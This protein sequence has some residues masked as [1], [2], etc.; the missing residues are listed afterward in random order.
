MKNLI[1]LFAFIATINVISQSD[2]YPV[3]AGKTLVYKY[4]AELYAGTPYVD[5][6]CEVKILEETEIINGK[7]YR[8]STSKTGVESGTPTVI[9][10]YFRYDDDGNLLTLADK[11]AEERIALTSSPKV[12]DVLSNDQDEEKVTITS[13]TASI[14]TPAGVY[15]DCMLMEVASQ[16]MQMRMYY[17]KNVG[18]VASAMMVEGEEKIFTYLVK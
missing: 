4:G 16:E 18:L 3:E 12:G 13:L 10:S 6:K 1:L 9:K 8:V 11:N 5:Y 2:Y 17:Q 15:S 14:E 7:E